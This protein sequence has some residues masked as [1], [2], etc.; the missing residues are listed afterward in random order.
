M[1]KLLLVLFS[2]I[3]LC[4]QS[5]IAQDTLPHIAVKKLNT[6]ILVSWKNT[7]GATITNINIQRSADSLR[8]FTSIGSI[9]E[10]MNSE[11]GYVDNKAPHDSMY[12]R[13]FVTFAG[14]RYVFSHSKKPIEDTSLKANAIIA[15]NNESEETGKSSATSRTFLAS[16][17]VYT[18]KDNNVIINLHSTYPENFSVKFFDERENNLFEIAKLTEQF[19][20]VDKVNFKHSGW[21]YFQLFEK[22]ALKEKHKFFIGKENKKP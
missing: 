7:Y 13:V 1:Q 19:L 2:F 15:D 8:N 22:G 16:R 5:A 9:L 20:I 10:P 14:G 3:F 21:F 6:K 11:N 4:R 18:A 12:Y 17:F